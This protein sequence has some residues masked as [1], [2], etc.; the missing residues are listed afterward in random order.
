MVLLKQ[1]WLLLKQIINH[2]NS[3]ITVYFNKVADLAA[4]MTKTFSNPGGGAGG[5]APQRRS[6]ALA[7]RA[8]SR[9]RRRDSD[10]ST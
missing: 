6:D 5:K 10:G 1:L 4:R 2:R 9:S 7:S 8:A 3:I